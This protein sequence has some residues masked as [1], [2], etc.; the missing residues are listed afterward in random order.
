M[1]HRPFEALFCGLRALAPAALLCAQFGLAQA[2]PARWTV[3]TSDELA[4]NLEFVQEL[5]E[6]Q[7]PGARFEVVRVARIATGDASGKAAT[8]DAVDTGAIV[9]R[10]ARAVAGA[11]AATASFTSTGRPSRCP[12]RPSC[13]RRSARNAISW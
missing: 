10:G 12:T 9:T 2:A 3:L 1:F 11:S 6:L 4:A 8:G 7:E 13:A 5:R